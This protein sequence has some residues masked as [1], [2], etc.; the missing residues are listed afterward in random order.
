MDWQEAVEAVKVI[1]PKMAVPMHYGS[2]VGSE[3]DARKFK[4]KAECRVEII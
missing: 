4:E 3:E 2:V 1:K